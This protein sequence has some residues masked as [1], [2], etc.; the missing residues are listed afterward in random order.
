MTRQA[1]G[2]KDKHR[3]ARPVRRRPRRAAEIQRALLSW[4][5]ANRRE[6]PWR[7]DCLTPYQ[8]LIAEVLLKRTTARAAARVYGSFIAKYP[9]L[10]SLHSAQVGEVERHLTEVG[11]YRQRAQG[12]KEMAHYLIAQCGSQVPLDLEALLQVPHVGPYAARAVV[13][14]GHR[15]PAAVV[16]SNVQRVLGRLFRRRLGLAPSLSSVQALADAILPNDSHRDFNWAL[17][18]LGA[19]VCRYDKPRCNVCPLVAPCSYVKRHARHTDTA[20]GSP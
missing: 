11:L 1:S 5:A 20:G 4:A 13:S 18:D 15:Q 16:D 2:P 17:L 14:F 19:T 9:D 10:E 3:P 7:E 12:L 6:Y 8:I